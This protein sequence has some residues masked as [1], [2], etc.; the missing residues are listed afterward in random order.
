MK[1]YVYTCWHTAQHNVVWSWSVRDVVVGD[2][3]GGRV[4]GV[5]KMFKVRDVSVELL[6]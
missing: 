1:Y 5:V 4:V 2:A 3:W 6:W